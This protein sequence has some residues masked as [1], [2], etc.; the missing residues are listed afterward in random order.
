MRLDRFLTENGYVESR[1]QAKNL[2]ECGAVTV[3]GSPVMKPSFDVS[4]GDEIN[5]K[6][7]LICPYVSRGGLKLEGALSEFAIDPTG[8]ICLDIGASSGGFTDCLLKNGA[9]KVYAVDSGSGQ[10]HSS[11]RSECRVISLENVNARYLSESEIPEKIDI[12]VMDVS[13][14][15]QT[16]LYPALVP[17]L[18]NGGILI[19]LIKPQFEVGRSGVGKGGIVRDDKKRKEAVEFVIETAASYGLTNIKTMVSPIKGG[20]GNTEFLA[21]FVKERRSEL[22]D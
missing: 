1:T 9:S 7:E 10:L 2:I 3:N 8:A 4:D 6:S 20:D 22:E 5:C 12:A 21:Y 13:F 17:L 11:L 18:K 14:I 16:K 15:S 19:S